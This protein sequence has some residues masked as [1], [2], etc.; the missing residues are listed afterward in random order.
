M[1]TLSA[2]PRGINEEAGPYRPWRELP[3]L[4]EG[5]DSLPAAFVHAA[6]RNA[7]RTAITDS[8]RAACTYG[9][10]FLRALAM[11]RVLA[12][13]WGEA[14]HVGLLVP[15]VVPAAIAN[16]AVALWG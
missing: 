12:R 11:G 8:T 6:R 2:N 9:D 4:P 14:S 7:S 13:T 5:W 1:T 3:P 10:T 15:P 16:L